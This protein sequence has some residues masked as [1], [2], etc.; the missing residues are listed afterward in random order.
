MKVETTQIR[1]IEITEVDGMDPISVYLEDL[2]PGKGKA[3]ITT[4]SRSWSYEWWAIGNDNDI[5]KFLIGCDEVYL[6]TKMYDGERWVTD[7]DAIPQFIRERAIE[8]RRDGY[9]TREEA[10]TVYDFASEVERIGPDEHA[11][12]LAYTPK[13][14]LEV[15]PDI[16]FELPTRKSDRLEYFHKIILTV[17]EALRAL[18]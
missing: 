6:G 5:R 4:P 15:W 3:T 2:A 8:T 18:E 7:F 14:V 1:K 9:V 11:W 13:E 17:Q 16:A 12:F 10:R